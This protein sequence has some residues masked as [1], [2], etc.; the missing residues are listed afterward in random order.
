MGV[1][2]VDAG[3]LPLGDGHVGHAA[4]EL[5]SLHQVALAARLHHVGAGQ[6]LRPPPLHDRVT[7]R[8]GHVVPVVG[9][10]FPEEMGAPLVAGEASRITPLYR[11]GI[12]FGEADHLA[13][14]PTPAP[15]RGPPGPWQASQFCCS[16]AVRA[17]CRNPLP[18]T[19]CSKLAITAGVVAR[20]QATQISDPTYS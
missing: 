14:T 12:I 18:I 5:G 2:A 11:G 13:G 3:H 1:V 9:A 8:A 19:V 17:L 15:P 10:P 4:E 20:W 6:L 7:A 16:R